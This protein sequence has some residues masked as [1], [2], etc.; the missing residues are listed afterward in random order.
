MGI[1]KSYKEG[2]YPFKCA[3][4]SQQPLHFLDSGGNRIFMPQS[5]VN[6]GKREL[7]VYINSH[8]SLIEGFWGSFSSLA[9]LPC[10]LHK[11]SVPYVG[12]NSYTQRER[13]RLVFENHDERVAMRIFEDTEQ[14]N[15]CYPSLFAYQS[16]LGSLLTNYLKSCSW[17][18]LN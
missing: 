9:L 8:K 18:I 11:Q 4:L 5:C 7:G 3:L 16:C 14:D 15:E 17:K 10:Q 13:E 6:Q 2:T 12:I 1:E